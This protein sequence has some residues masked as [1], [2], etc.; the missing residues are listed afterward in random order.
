MAHEQ[1]AQLVGAGNDLVH[2]ETLDFLLAPVLAGEFV[3]RQHRVVAGVIG[4]MDGRPVAHEIVVVDREVIRDRDRLRMGDEEAVIRPLDRRPTSHLRR[5]ARPAE[6][7]RGAAPVIVPSAIRREMALMAAPTQLGRLHALSDEAVDRPGVDELARLLGKRGNLGV[8]LGDVDH[9]D[10]ELRR[11]RGPFGARLGRGDGAHR[12]GD[13]EER[14]LDEMR[15]EAR[16]GAVRQHRRRPARPGL[17]Q[18]Q[19][20]LAQGI[21][22]ARRRQQPAVGIAARPGLDAGVEIERAFSAAKLNQGDARDLDR[23]VEQKIARL[24]Q[25][26]EHGKIIFLRQSLDEE[27]NAEILGLVAAALRR[28]DDGDLRR[29]QVDMA[30]D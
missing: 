10:A 7:D 24:Q 22:G 23:D 19:G 18:R 30:E 20:V 5:G 1:D 11:K 9:F 14:G 21:V 26:V 3:K 12:L 17:A 13:V 28:S 16:V 4:V 25:R 29:R 15:D 6:V 8:A 27:A 2:D